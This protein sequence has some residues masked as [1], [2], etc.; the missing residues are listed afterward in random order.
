MTIFFSNLFEN[1]KRYS[2][3]YKLLFMEIEVIACFFFFYIKCHLIYKCVDTAYQKSKNKSLYL[4][5]NH[6]K[7]EQAYI[8]CKNELDVLLWFP[9][10]CQCR[11][12]QR[13]PLLNVYWINRLPYSEFELPLARISWEIRNEAITSNNREFRLSL[14]FRL[15]PKILYLS[16]TKL[17][18]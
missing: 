10:Q 17:F 11:L 8:T 2:M 5:N 7:E 14:L 6:K 16:R 4:Q 15:P 1:F 18:V 13:Y 9:S 3:T 12:N